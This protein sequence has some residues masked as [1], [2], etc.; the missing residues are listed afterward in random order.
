MDLHQNVNHCLIIKIRQRRERIVS[1]KT[2]YMKGSPDLYTYF[3]FYVEFLSPTGKGVVFPSQKQA[4][5]RLIYQE[6]I[7]AHIR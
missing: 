7:S 6:V 2:G 5:E 1:Y 3:G 4:I